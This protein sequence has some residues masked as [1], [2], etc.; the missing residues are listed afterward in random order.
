MANKYCSKCGAELPEDAKF[1]IKCGHPTTHLNPK[2]KRERVHKRN[3]KTLYSFIAV[4]GVLLLVIL[5]SIFFS[6]YSEKKEAELSRQKKEML[7]PMEDVLAM[8][9][10]NTR[11]Y[12]LSKIEEYGYKYFGED[13][14][15]EYYS[16]DVDLK[17]VEDWR[18]DIHYEP[19]QRTGSRVYL[20][21]SSSYFNFGITVFSKDDFI[22]WEEQLKDLGYKEE[23]YG[24]D[25]P[26]E[27][28]WTAL[29]AHGNLCKLYS[30]GKGN[31]IEFMK[32]GDGHPGYDVYTVEF[33]K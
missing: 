8:Y 11:S 21:K 3:T 24:E 2:T 27:G 15:N 12:V 4:I 28:S 17:M 30:D 19:V 9:K 5:G 20:S 22:E 26:M 33:D 18:G 31:S 23:S 6:S 16:K 13:E 7:I 32:D 1:C 29:G 14:N 10:T 25:L